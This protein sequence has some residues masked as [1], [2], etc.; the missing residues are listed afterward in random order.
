MADDTYEVRLCCTEDA[1][2]PIFRFHYTSGELHWEVEANATW[3][4]EPS[5]VTTIM[6]RVRG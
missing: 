3:D 1:Y 4:W 5:G 2:C 6:G